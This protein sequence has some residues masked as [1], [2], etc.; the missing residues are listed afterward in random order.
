MNE[1]AARMAEMAQGDD[2]DDDHS[3]SA[4]SAT[5]LELYQSVRGMI[6]DG[7]VRDK[8]Q[9]S[10]KSDCATGMRRRLSILNTHEH[11]VRAL[12]IR[13]VQ[14]RVDGGKILAALR[15]F[16]FSNVSTSQIQYTVVYLNFRRL[17]V[18]L[19]EL[20]GEGRSLYTGDGSVDRYSLPRENFF[21]V[22]SDS[23]R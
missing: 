15:F 13:S 6:P 1:D 5:S 9:I 22:F 23:L 7:H 3:P 8:D 10:M 16:C 17:L 20:C 21:H 19:P 18:S 2:D 14:M 4:G 11:K 12:I